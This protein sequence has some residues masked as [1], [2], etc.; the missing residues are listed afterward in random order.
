VFHFPYKGYTQTTTKKGGGYIIFFR[1]M[2]N[3]PYREHT[4]TIYSTQEQK[5]TKNGTKPPLYDDICPKNNQ[6]G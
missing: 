3:I 6:K 2:L 5:G 1:T 4:T